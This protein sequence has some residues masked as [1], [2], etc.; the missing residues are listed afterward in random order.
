MIQQARPGSPAAPP[1]R[2]GGEDISQTVPM[3]SSRR[4]IQIG[5]FFMM[6]I[7][8]VVVALLMLTDPGTFRGRY[9]IVTSVRDAGGL[10]KGDPVQMRGVNVGRVRGFAITDQG[11]VINMEMEREYPV[12]ADSRISLKSGGLLG[13]MIV[14][15]VPG[16]S[17]DAVEDGAVLPG[18]T[19]GGVFDVATGVAVRADTVLGRAG[20]L[21]A[22]ATVQ[23]V[24]ASAQEL[25]TMLTSLAALATEQRREIAL[26]SSSLRRSAEGVESAATRPELQR[27]VA[28]MD[29]ITLQLDRSTA[30]LSRTSASLETVLGRMERGEGTLGKLSADES[31]YNNLNQAAARASQ[32][33]AN[34]DSLL[35]DI[36][37][38]PRR[39]IDLRVF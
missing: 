2:G 35:A 39:Y 18:S 5:F 1:K 25:Q 4:E 38:N 9:D 22:P 16:R 36:K 29:S 10:R 14:E 37:E 34:A 3:R 19:A 28:R 23:A 12:P 13:G 20:E 21:L 33:A 11:V 8:A 6:G 17:D 15:V 27:A 31:L 30:S 26:L 32:T 7:V 24:G